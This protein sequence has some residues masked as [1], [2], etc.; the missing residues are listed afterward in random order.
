MNNKIKKVV[1][2]RI[3]EMYPKKQKINEIEINYKD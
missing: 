2:K 3:K 1:I